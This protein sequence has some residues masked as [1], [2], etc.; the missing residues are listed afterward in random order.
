MMPSRI[1]H[2]YFKLLLKVAI[3]FCKVL[4]VVAFFTFICKKKEYIINQSVT[5]YLRN[6][7]SKVVI[8]WGKVHYF[9]FFAF[10]YNK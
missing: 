10:N 7:V 1:T 5:Y 3:S 6:S 9:A 8:S 4:F 2:R